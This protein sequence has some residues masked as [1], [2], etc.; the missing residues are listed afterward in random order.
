[1]DKNV[2]E[3]GVVQCMERETW[4]HILQYV[5]LAIRGICYG[6]GELVEGD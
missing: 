6:V 1:M 3:E 2:G 5:L 4:K